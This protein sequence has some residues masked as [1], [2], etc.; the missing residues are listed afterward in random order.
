M[1]KKIMAILLTLTMAGI[2]FAGCGGSKNEV[3]EDASSEVGQESAIT[4]ESEVKE[5]PAAGGNKEAVTL[6]MWVWDDAQVPATQA[7]VDEFHEMHPNINIEITSIAGVQDYN[8][9]M[10][11]VIGT[12]DAPSVFWI[13]FNLAKEYIPMG[14]VQDLTE[15]INKDSEFDITKLN[16]GITDAYTVDGKI[17]GIAKDTDGFAVFL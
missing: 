1:R 8:T 16:A 13:N 14:F 4:A 2:L 10:Q 6:T 12:K 3:Q 17:Y 15:Y 11:T 7:M 5:S 9:K